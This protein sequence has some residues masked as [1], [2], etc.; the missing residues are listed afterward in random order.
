MPGTSKEYVI[1]ISFTQVRMVIVAAR[2]RK[3]YK[4]ELPK[5]QGKKLLYDVCQGA[6]E[7]AQRVRLSKAETLYIEGLKELMNSTIDTTNV[8]Q[9][10]INPPT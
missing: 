4:L 6:D 3:H 9:R 7:F 5:K 10:H 1:E 2:K 8:R